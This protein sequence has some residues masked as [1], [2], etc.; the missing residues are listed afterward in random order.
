[1]LRVKK[2]CGSDLSGYRTLNT[3]ENFAEIKTPHDAIE[4]FDLAEKKKLSP[5]V[6]GAGS[7]VFFKNSYI[8]SFVLRNKIPKE[9][10]D[11]GEDR[12]EVS[13]SVT[14]MELL[15]YMYA[16][17]RDCCYYLASAPCQ[18]GGAIAMNAGSGK[19]ENKTISDYIIS[20]SYV[21]GTRG[22]L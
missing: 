1:M 3:A 17:S 18:V 2:Y 8:K 13:S 15:K 21:D 14:M 10:K 9:I 5:F 7:N 12:F 22:I 11:L 6:L 19:L 4:A 20:V 16:Q